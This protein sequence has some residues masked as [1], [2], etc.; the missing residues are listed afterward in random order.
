MNHY[1]ECVGYYCYADVIRFLDEDNTG[2][3]RYDYTLQLI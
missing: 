3:M 2:I 1:K